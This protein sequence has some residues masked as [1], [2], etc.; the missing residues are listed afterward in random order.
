MS[1]QE[2]IL[3][4]IFGETLPDT[5]QYIEKTW[6]E[7]NSQAGVYF[8]TIKT[9][10][11]VFI[12]FVDNIVATPDAPV[13][14]STKT[15]GT[16][17]YALN[18]FRKLAAQAGAVR[19]YIQIE[20][21]NERLSKLLSRRY[22]V[23]DRVPMLPIGKPPHEKFKY[24]EIF[25]EDYQNR[26]FL[27]LEI[28]LPVHVLGAPMRRFQTFFPLS[29]SIL[30]LTQSFHSN[31]TG[32]SAFSYLRIYADRV[33]DDFFT[34]IRK[35]WWVALQVDSIVMEMLSNATCLQSIRQVYRSQ[36]LES[37]IKRIT[38]IEAQL[39]GINPDELINVSRMIIKWASRQRMLDL[40]FEE[41]LNVIHQD[42]WKKYGND[43]GPTP[44]YL[45]KKYKTTQELAA[46]SKRFREDKQ[47]RDIFEKSETIDDKMANDACHK[48]LQ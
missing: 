1:N 4:D 36:S 11:N 37:E 12:V 25:D 34:F 41:Q 20:P 6:G 15:S 48:N 33:P 9:K 13:C 44:D 18:H 47:I 16:L 14:A 5:F 43:I 40:G 8:C 39:T 46:A 35:N 30:I 42:N 31:A 22:R 3:N 28:P 2:K 24:L 29:S 21:E 27:T 26:G 10:T 7:E 38:N 23:R 32:S 19:L 17:L 45:A